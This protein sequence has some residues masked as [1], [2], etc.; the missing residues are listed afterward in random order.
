MAGRVGGGKGDSGISWEIL[1]VT[2]L[3]YRPIIYF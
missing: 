1:T 2:P 3:F